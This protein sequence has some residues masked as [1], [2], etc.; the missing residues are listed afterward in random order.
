[1][2][3]ICQRLKDKGTWNTTHPF[4]QIVIHYGQ[5]L[6]VVTGAT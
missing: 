4:G 6:F 3:E 1:M 5:Q 2:S